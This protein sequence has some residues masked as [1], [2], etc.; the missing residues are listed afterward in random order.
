MMCFIEERKERQPPQPPKRE[1][2][3]DPVGTALIG[4]LAIGS[5]VTLVAWF[6]VLGGWL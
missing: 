3:D 6:A 4:A 2:A 5:V 1:R